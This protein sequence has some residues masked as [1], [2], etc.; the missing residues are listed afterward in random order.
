MYSVSMTKQY[1]KGTIIDNAE[2]SLDEWLTLMKTSPEG[3]VFPNYMFP[4]DAIADEFIA[5]IHDYNELFV[6][7]ILAHFL[8][9]RGLLGSDQ[10]NLDHLK[11]LLVE[12][13]AAADQLLRK[14][15]YH[16]R[17]FRHMKTRGAAPLYPNIL[18]VPDLL[19]TAPRH[20]L[21][22]VEA[23]QHVSIA[24]LPDG[25]I[26]G[27]S[28]AE[29]IIRARYF[30]AKTDES[31]LRSLSPED[32]EHVVEALY[33]G[34]DYKTEM[35]Q[36]THDGG[37]DVIATRS[38]VGHKEKIMISCKRYTDTVPVSEVR[39]I[40][41]P[42]SQHHAT[43]GVIVTTSGFSVDAT[44]LAEEH[45]QLELINQ[46]S[47]QGLLNEH[48]GSNWSSRVAGIVEGSKRRHPKEKRVK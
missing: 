2:L 7:T 15:L 47:L 20:A 40:F 10:L 18:W 33:D 30:G 35:T 23:F 13:R 37:R 41:A 4:N 24:G 38:E 42:L 21:N 46:I 43:K 1:S 34:M 26:H 25:R 19:P 32:F 31:V 5:H 11:R 27:V 39:E 29:R 44:K 14:S 9:F 45:S 8:D 3:V 17:L 6:K 36:A 48:L 16:R 12:D 22:V 28:D